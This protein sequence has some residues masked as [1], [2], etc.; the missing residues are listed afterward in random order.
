MRDTLGAAGTS[1]LVLFDEIENISPA[2]AA[3]PHWRR[4]DDTV[5][6]WQTIRSF[7]QSSLKVRA[8]FCFVGTNPRL[9]ELSKFNSI[10]NPVY[11]FAPKAFIPML[12]LEETTEMINR[13]GYFMD[14]DFAPPIIGYIYQK[15]G[16]HPFLVR[17][18]C[19]KIHKQVLLSRPRQIPS[20]PARTQNSRPVQICNHI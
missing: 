1:V 13:L 5:L 15:L 19:S 8:T 12:T 17:Q 7:Y 20:N 3:S 2:T 9:F 4:G 18:L 11:L 6:F 10:D 16:G 14:L